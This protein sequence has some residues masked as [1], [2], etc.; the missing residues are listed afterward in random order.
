MVQSP[1]NPGAKPRACATIAHGKIVT[2]GLG[3][4]SG[5]KAGN[6][7]ASTVA[8]WPADETIIGWAKAKLALN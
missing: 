7:P 4:T 8:K 1:E 6:D 2:P 5:Q 3:G